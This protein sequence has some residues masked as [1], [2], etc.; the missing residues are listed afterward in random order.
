MRYA[1]F[2]R[3]R[4]SCAAQLT[5]LVALGLGVGVN[6]D[7]PIIVKP[8]PAAVFPVCAV[9]AHGALSVVLD[10]SPQDTLIAYAVQ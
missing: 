1:L 3:K 2:G 7:L 9:Q 8:D 5:S 6:P 10:Y 4:I